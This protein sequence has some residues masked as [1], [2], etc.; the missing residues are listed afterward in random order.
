M[1]R[2]HDGDLEGTRL[3]GYSAFDGDAAEQRGQGSLPAGA[4][5]AGQEA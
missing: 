2:P 3:P 4:V 1:A 5:R